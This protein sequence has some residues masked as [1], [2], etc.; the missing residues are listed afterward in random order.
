MILRALLLEQLALDLE[1][2]LL[3]LALEGMLLVLDM[4]P[5]MALVLGDTAYAL[6]P[7][8]LHTIAECSKAR[9]YKAKWCKARN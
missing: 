1:E 2:M 9:W 6:L 7:L 5:Y 8:D 3:I 4:K